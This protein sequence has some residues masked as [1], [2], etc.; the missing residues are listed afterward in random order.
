MWA[1]VG[2][3]VTAL[4]I[5]ILGAWL[6]AAFAL[7]RFQKERW[8]ERKEAAYEAVVG[9]L[10]SLRTS[11]QMYAIWVATKDQG[12]AAKEALRR[13]ISDSENVGR[14]LGTGAFLLGADAHHVLT[15]YSQN[16]N[17]LIS[18][19]VSENAA[20]GPRYYVDLANLAKE[21][22]DKFSKAAK[23]DLSVD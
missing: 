14:A 9:A 10:Y 23:H 12:P 3:F 6:G 17:D 8:W 22:L 16:Q 18:R 7:R 11:S 21:C 15:S 4:I 20:L 2:Q 1:L 5:G 13:F 19:H